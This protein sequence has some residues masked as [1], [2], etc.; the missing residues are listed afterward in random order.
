MQFGH[1]SQAQLYSKDL[2]RHLTR[3]H[4]KHLSIEKKEVI[5]KIK[6]N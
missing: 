3:I 6:T 1:N 5:F 4:T 2:A